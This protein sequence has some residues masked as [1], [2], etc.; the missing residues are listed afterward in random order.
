[1]IMLALSGSLGSSVIWPFL[2]LNSMYSSP[3]AKIVVAG[4]LS[5]NIRLFIRKER[6]VLIIPSIVHS[7]TSRYLSEVAPLHGVHIGRVEICTALFADNVLT[8]TSDPHHY[9]ATIKSHL[10]EV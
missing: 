3:M 5:D 6:R 2:Q 10:I 8:F 4:L 7:R 1:M 9:M